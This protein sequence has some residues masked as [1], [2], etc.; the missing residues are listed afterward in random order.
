M[1]DAVAHEAP[2]LVLAPMLKI[3]IPE[4]VSSRYL[5]LIVHP[6]IKGDGRPSSLDWAIFNGEKSW[7]VS[8]LEARLPNSMR[9]RSGRHTS[10]TST[11]IVLRKA[12]SIVVGLPRR[13]ARRSRGDRSY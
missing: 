11:A 2:D 6:G 5:C 7:G 10:L 13:F 8:I 12:A 4:E 1:I 3:A 9:G